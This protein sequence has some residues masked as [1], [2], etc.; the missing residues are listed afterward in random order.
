MTDSFSTAERRLIMQK[1]KGK[2]NRSTEL[3]LI[4]IFKKHGIKGWKR[5]YSVI[6]KPDFVFL[7][8]RIVVFADGC[9]WHGHH[10]RNITPKQNSEYW[11]KKRQRNTDRDAKITQLFEHRGWTVVR[12]WECDIRKENLNLTELM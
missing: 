10:C 12:F 7:N 11:K 9:F 6:G 1:V 4:S 3:A 2:K 5:N 8:K